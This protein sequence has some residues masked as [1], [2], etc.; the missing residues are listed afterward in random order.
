M[1]KKVKITLFILIGILVLLGA[2]IAILVNTTWFKEVLIKRELRSMTEEFYSFQYAENGKKRYAK[3]FKDSGLSVSLGDMKIILESRTGKK[4]DSK[5]LEK[6]DIAKTKS[7]I[8]PT[9]PFGKKDYRLDFILSC[10]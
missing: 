7:L 1:S 5:R 9:D 10:K 8:Y 6:C 2:G 4:Y 3:K